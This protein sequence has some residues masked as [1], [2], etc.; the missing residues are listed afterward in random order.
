MTDKI[1][2]KWIGD[3]YIPY[4]LPEGSTLYEVDLDKVV[5]CCSCGRSVKYGE[6]YTSRRIHTE[7]GLGY[8]ECEKC[9]YENLK[10]DLK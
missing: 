10:K 1:V 7:F 4:K 6:T 8:A 5:S 2:H 9:Y 3:K